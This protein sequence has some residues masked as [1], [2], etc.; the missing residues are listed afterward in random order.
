MISFFLGAPASYLAAM[1]FGAVVGLF[2]ALVFR[3]H[4]EINYLCHE[5]H[6]ADLPRVP[7]HMSG[8]YQPDDR[9]KFEAR[10]VILRRRYPDF[11][12]R[13]FRC[14][15]TAR[16]YAAVAREELRCRAEAEAPER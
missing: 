12:E 2:G 5:S 16:Y 14:M 13:A 10:I 3:S 4:R 6:G 8:G 9:E 15:G 11:N 1:I 7:L